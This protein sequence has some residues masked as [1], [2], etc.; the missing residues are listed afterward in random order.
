MEPNRLL[1]E[2]LAGRS[3]NPHLLLVISV[4]NLGVFKNNYFK[5]RSF[6]IG[7]NTHADFMSDWAVSWLTP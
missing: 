7:L 4:I 5:S 3:E 2:Q 6:S 1:F